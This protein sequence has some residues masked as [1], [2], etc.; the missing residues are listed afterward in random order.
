MSGIHSTHPAVSVLLPCRNAVP[1]LEECLDSLFV[2]TLSNIEVIAVDDGSSDGTLAVLTRI[3]CWP[4]QRSSPV[5]HRSRRAERR[6]G[7]VPTPAWAPAIV[8]TKRG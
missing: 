8:A 3:D 2:Q 4:R 6:S 1:W 5:I 7:C